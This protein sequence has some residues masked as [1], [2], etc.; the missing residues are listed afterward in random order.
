MKFR[1]ELEKSRQSRPF[2]F[3]ILIEIKAIVNRIWMRF[4]FNFALILPLK[5]KFLSIAHKLDLFFYYLYRYLIV[6]R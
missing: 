3:N 5:K 1:L 4:Y 2:I 6:E